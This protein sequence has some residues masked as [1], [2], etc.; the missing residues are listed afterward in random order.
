MP[1][2]L[3]GGSMEQRWQDLANLLSLQSSSHDP[4]GAGLHQP[5][6]HH[7]AP[8]PYHP[9]HHHHHHPHAPT[10]LH[11]SMHP[12]HFGSGVPPTTPYSTD[13]ARSVLLQN[14]TLAPP[15]LNSTG[16]YG[17]V[18]M[19]AS[20]NLGSAVASS[21]HLTNSSEPMIDPSSHYKMM[22][23]SHDMLYY[24][25]STNEMAN[26][27]SAADGFNLSSILNDDE[28]QLMDMAMSEGMYTMRVMENGVPSSN[29]TTVGAPPSVSHNGTSAACSVLG[30]TGGAASTEDRM[31][32]SSDSAVSSMGSERVPPMTDPPMSDNEWVDA[33]S[34]PHGPHDLS[35]Y[36]MDYSRGK[37]GGYDYYKDGSRVPGG[38]V[39][40]KKH[41]M[42]G[43][44]FQQEQ[45]SHPYPL[46][47]HLPYPQAGST[48][49]GSSMDLDKYS[50]GTDFGRYNGQRSL[51]S[52]GVDPLQSNHTYSL[53]PTHPD[54]PL[55]KTAKPAQKEKQ[56]MIKY[57]KADESLT[58]DEKKA[59]AMSIPITTEDIINLPMDEFN[60]RLSK[61]DL[62]ESQLS[63]IRD[64]RRRGKNKV[65]AQNCRK[66]K[67]DQI[68]QLAD[69]VSRIRE[70][71]QSLMREQQGLLSRRTEL[72]ERYNLL[73]RTVTQ[74]LRETDGNPYSPYGYNIQ[75]AADGNVVLV[76]RNPSQP[77]TST[78]SSE[79]GMSHSNNHHGRRDKSKDESKKE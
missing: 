12:P 9:H 6:P 40:Q 11:H 75:H 28:L 23:P 27:T 42:F 53:A 30:A 20:S 3:R 4:S 55:M 58:R 73:C 62:S 36:S 43:K 78:T 60:E 64:I 41:H 10:P 47:S 14:A 2:L 8:H 45:S 67:L 59:R 21:M 71:K 66:R 24:Q 38:P 17:N 34:H 39:A 63:L 46:P 19:G 1:G 48:S 52:G 57:F 7:F 79:N 25:N 35:P 51:G 61:Y 15:E 54:N 32:A 50:C 31:E 29:L 18:G 5:I 56:K 44:R 33:D 77:S 74:A 37:L 26:Q 69:E 22:D 13:T 70:R 76:P 68:L 49:Q 65:A 16:P 72:K